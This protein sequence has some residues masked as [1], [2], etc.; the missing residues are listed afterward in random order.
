MKGTRFKAGTVLEA[1][2]D[3]KQKLALTDEEVKFFKKQEKVK[4]G[5]KRI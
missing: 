3:L 1:Y 2:F 5:Q 4:N